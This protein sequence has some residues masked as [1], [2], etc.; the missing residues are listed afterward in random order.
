MVMRWGNV[1]P[2]DLHE[3]GYRRQHD[4]REDFIGWA[5]DS[6]KMKVTA[7]PPLQSHEGFQQ[8]L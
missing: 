5:E 2:Q 4:L 6:P 7:P 1:V 8:T 3:V